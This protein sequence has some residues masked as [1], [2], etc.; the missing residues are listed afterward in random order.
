MT[1]SQ[2]APTVARLVRR[3]REGDAAA[4][5][6]LVR[7]HLPLVYNIVGRALA[8]H[9]DVDDVVQE[10]MFRALRA[11]PSLREP[12]RFRSWLVAIAYRQIQLHLR[13]RR[14][15]R[16]QLVPEQAEVPDPAGD[17]AERTTAELVL[18]GQRRDLVEAARWLDADDRRL[19]GLWWQEAA[20]ELSR[21]ELADALGV[22]PKH[23]AVRVQRMKAQLDAVRGVVGALHARPRCPELAGLVRHWNGI[24]DPL[25]RKRLVRHVRECAHCADRGRGLIAPEQLLLGAAMLPVPA[26]LTAKVSALTVTSNAVL[27][28]KILAA[29]GTAAVLATGGGIVYAVHYSPAP[30]PPAVVAV[31]PPAPVFTTTPR[32]AASSSAP[33]ATGEDIYVAPDGSDDGDG[34][35]GQPFATLGK[36]VATVR[37]GQTIALRGGTYRPAAAVE[38]TTSGTPGK[39]ITLTNYRGEKPVIDASGVPADQWAVT[40][41]A[42]YW[43]VQGLTITGSA[44]HAYVCS[45]CQ[46]SIF[47]RLTMR[48]NARSGLQL[49][50]EGTT[51]NQILD[52]DFT[53]GDGTGLS[54]QFGSGPGNVV[55]GNRFAANALA[56]IDL[57]AFTSPVTLEYNWAYDNGGTGFVLGGGSPP[58]TAAHKLRHN[59]AWSNG[60][61]GFSD[62]G[63]TAALDLTNNTAWRNKDTGFH[64]PAAAATVRADV[65]AANGTPY[66]LGP[67]ATQSRSTA[68]TP[69]TSTDPAEATGPR[70][71]NGKLPATAFLRTG[72]GTGASMAGN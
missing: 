24:A 72:N 6:A 62:E 2:I 69:F 19:L 56:G 42:S 50:D 28:H 52:S 4:T 45:G 13:A 58:A 61:H 35:L 67:A 41:R 14:T 32:P 70:R 39:R 15:S 37:P 21:T 51:G 11:L 38:I 65:S 7:E 17:F 47:R 25:W 8:G 40:Q 16:L 59:A 54:I 53:G 49:R 44:S 60:S 31:A 36:A 9:P 1:Q 57:G 66:D 64:L 3:A 33:I 5:E 68:D 18:D 48:D 46:G 29:C 63:N 71:T 12:E 27:H 43:T 55:R 34:S 10:T 23:A 22:R 30:P 26:A 20:G